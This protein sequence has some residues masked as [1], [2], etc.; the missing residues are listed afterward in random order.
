MV[1]IHTKTNENLEKKSLKVSK[2]ET[3]ELP[4]TYS[5]LATLCR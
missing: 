5:P 4:D 2:I 1:K 3:S